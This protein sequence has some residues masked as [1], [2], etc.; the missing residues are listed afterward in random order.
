MNVQTEKQNALV[1]QLEVHKI[2][3]KTRAN[4]EKYRAGTKRNGIV[5]SVRLIQLSAVG[6]RFLGGE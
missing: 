1:K 6:E 3:R 5:E 4:C 2:R